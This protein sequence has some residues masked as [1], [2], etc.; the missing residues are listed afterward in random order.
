MK[1]GNFCKLLNKLIHYGHSPNCRQLQYLSNTLGVYT[2]VKDDLGVLEVE[3][4]A[5]A[6]GQVMTQLLTHWTSLPL[7]RHHQQPDGASLALA[8]EAA[9]LSYHAQEVSNMAAASS[10]GSQV[11]INKPLVF[12]TPLPSRSASPQKLPSLK[13]EEKNGSPKKEKRKGG[14][15]TSHS[16]SDSGVFTSESS[17]ENDE[18]DEKEETKP[19][20]KLKRTLRRKPISYRVKKKNE[21]NESSTSVE[22][23]VESK[24]KV[25]ELELPPV[26]KKHHLQVAERPEFVSPKTPQKLPSI[27]THSR[28]ANNHRKKHNEDRINKGK[29]IVEHK[30]NSGSL[31]TNDP[32]GA[33]NEVKTDLKVQKR[34]RP[35]PFPNRRSKSEEVTSS[36]S[37][38]KIKKTESGKEEAPRTS[39]TLVVDVGRSK[40][41]T[42]ISKT[43][44]RR[45][46][47]GSSLGSSLN[48]DLVARSASI[49]S[50]HSSRPV[51]SSNLGRKK[52]EETVEEKHDEIEEDK[53]LT[54]LKLDET[55][56]KDDFG[57]KAFPARL[58]SPRDLARTQTRL[59]IKSNRSRR[60]STNKQ[61]DNL[62][63]TI[64]HI[65]EESDYVHSDSHPDVVE[66][67]IENGDKFIRS[68]CRSDE[69]FCR[70]FIK[71]MILFGPALK[72]SSR[73]QAMIWIVLSRLA[74]YWSKNLKV[75]PR[76][77]EL[78]EDRDTIRNFLKICRLCLEILK[79]DQVQVTALQ[80]VR[81]GEDVSETFLNFQQFDITLNRLRLANF[82][83]CDFQDKKTF[84]DPLGHF[85]ECRFDDRPMVEFLAAVCVHVYD[86][87]IPE[88]SPEEMTIML[89]NLCGVSSVAK[90]KEQNLV[91]NFMEKVSAVSYVP[92]RK[93][94]EFYL[95]KRQL[96]NVWMNDPS[97]LPF[98]HSVY[99]SRMKN[100]HDKHPM[101]ESELVFH[102]S[103]LENHDLTSIA[104]YLNHLDKKHIKIASFVAKGCGLNDESLS[105]FSNKV[106]SVISFLVIFYITIK[107]SF[108]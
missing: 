79:T 92:I 24:D 67:R 76:E 51:L 77:E 61:G 13:E 31:I 56:T 53:H 81:D 35:P 9:K 41:D 100:I 3:D 103:K 18:K 108:S 39:E 58:T 17:K 90:D 15:K 78:L 22:T 8:L 60:S 38:R 75:P 1:K 95:H 37:P 69:W 62:R 54:L 55:F 86:E 68:L 47:K 104:Y 23:S 14:E 74:Q 93:E 59:S 91:I 36:K 46:L 71:A 105:T 33:D 97:P 88:I 64:N 20:K 42:V 5:S 63:E 84:G 102:D 19:T 57:N 82:D 4:S 107:C 27:N 40:S 85:V 29:K 6:R 26:N 89:P 12:H 101:A 65:L 44:R 32:P 7:S 106:K 50:L 25:P 94:S 45:G 28:T 83:I 70:N 34:Q 73:T 66:M 52:I 99:E 10:F 72:M 49:R 2:K 43:A 11:D 48:D 80:E 30:S 87:D 21:E 16:N 96:Q 98:F